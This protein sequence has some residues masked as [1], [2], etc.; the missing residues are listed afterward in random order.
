MIAEKAVPEPATEIANPFIGLRPFDVDDSPLFFGRNKESYELLRRLVSLHFLAVVGPSGC[1]KSSL[2]RAGVLAALRDG[3]LADDG[4]WKI[5]KL[6]PA[7]D[8]L[9]DWTR[10]LTPHLRK[11]FEPADLLTRP[12]K[13]L[14]GS[15]GRI[16]ILVDQFEDLFK[17]G[18]RTGDTKQVAAFL[19]AMLSTGDPEANIY[20]ILTMRSEYLADCAVYPDLADAINE[21][22]Y[23]VPRMPPDQMRQAIVGPVEKAGAAITVALVDRFLEDAS[24]EEDGLPILQH[25]LKEIWPCRKKWE[26]LGLDLY[27]AEGG[28]GEFVNQHAEKVY[29]ALSDPQKAVA[30]L[31]FRAIT[32]RTS[33]GRALRRALPFD[34]IAS[35]T[36]ADPDLLKQIIEAFR[37]GGFLWQSTGTQPELIDIVHE[38]VARQW[39]RLGAERWQTADKRWV[40]GWMITEARARRA[41]ETLTAAAVEWD[42]NGRENSY[43]FTGARLQRLLA[44]LGSRRIPKQGVERE[45][46][47]RSRKRDFWGTLLSPKVV[48]IAMFVIVFLAGLAICG[49]LLQNEASAAMQK[50]DK[51]QHAAAQAVVQTIVESQN[52]ILAANQQTLQAQTVLSLQAKTPEDLSA[53][54]VTAVRARIYPEV[55]NATQKQEFATALATLPRAGFSVMRF[56]TITVGPSKND[57]RYFKNANANEANQIAALLAKAGL[58]VQVVYVAGFEA[59]SNIRDRT[60]ELWAAKPPDADSK[61]P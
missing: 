52:A 34:Q 4:P 23:L 2:I 35:E 31:L 8:P 41:S 60:Y 17:F 33:D 46:L 13:A 21:G 37:D 28:L 36:G 44:D 15:S 39:K 12:A 19:D 10:L 1:G 43:L 29:N 14:D 26:P 55:W 20:T 56:E 5:I 42:R 53:T 16:A 25:A 49:L 47:D 27:P 32:E 40:E 9:S 59:N 3:Y 48:G 7:A 11:G 58:T 18:R 61:K 22:L 6:L 50:A 45:F 57:L 24:Y 38:A 51:A 30:E 54:P